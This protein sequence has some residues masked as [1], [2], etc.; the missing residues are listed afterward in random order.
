MIEILRPGALASIQDLGRNGMRRFGVGG[1]GA[2]DSLALRVGN[3]LLGNEPG[4]AAIEFT[5]G[6]AT[7]RFHA[8]LRI[9][10]TGA[11]CRADLDG[12]PVWCW[13]AFDV[14]AGS[15]LTLPAPRGGT[16][17]Y[18]CVAGGI[19]VPLAMG[20]RSTDLRAG[21]GGHQGRALRRGDR[22][23]ALR[24]GFGP[25]PLPPIG[26]LAPAW[27]LPLPSPS[28]PSSQS[29][30]S[31]SSPQ[32]LQSSPSQSLQSWQ[33]PQRSHSPRSPQSLRTPQ[34]S[35]SP[36]SADGR[37]LPIRMLPGLEYDQFEAD[38]QQALWQA[39]WTVT[40]NSN[41]MG[42][43]LEGPAL[44]RR[45]GAPELLSHG[46]VPGV[47]Q[48]P[49]GGQPIVLMA[50]AQTTGGYPKIGVVID[51]DLWRLAQAPLGAAVRFHRVGLEEAEAARMQ[52]QTYLRQIAQAVAWQSEARTGAQAPAARR[53]AMTRRLSPAD[54]TLP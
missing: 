1:T 7:V 37:A 46:V 34:S 15:T 21:F 13:H 23:A 27:A 53:R 52:V 10:L 35:P 48:V 6:R 17:T 14:R 5:L 36:A 31:S 44:A 8:D 12:E 25:A 24:P 11:E 28:S 41:R 22:L 33:S 4:A 3:L 38:A 40:P 43:R 30:Q 16:R 19:D 47:M 39:D 20:S 51:A 49:P 50:D 2:L 18:L 45:P 26:V 29:P 9:A 42:F 32:S 54:A